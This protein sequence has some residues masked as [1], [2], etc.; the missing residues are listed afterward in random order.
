MSESLQDIKRGPDRSTKEEWLLDYAI[1]SMKKFDKR[2]PADGVCTQAEDAA[3]ITKCTWQIINSDDTLFGVV[4]RQRAGIDASRRVRLVPTPLGVLFLRCLEIDLDYLSMVGPIDQANPFIGLFKR[5]VARNPDADVAAGLHLDQVRYMLPFWTKIRR[6]LSDDELW[7]F[8]YGLNDTVAAIREEGR[9]QPFRSDWRRHTRPAAKN[10]DSLVEM[11]RAL[12]KRH[13]RLLVV[14]VDFGYGK[15][16]QSI[17]YAEVRKHR[18]TLVRYLRRMALS[19]RK[20]FKAYALKLE[21]GL[22]KKWHFHALMFLDGNNVQ[23]GVHHAMTFGEHWKNVITKGKGVYYNCHQNRWKYKTALGI[24]KIEAHEF[25]PRRALETNVAG[26]LVKPDFYGQMMKDA[27]DRLFFKSELPE[28]AERK[29]GRKR[30][31]QDAFADLGSLALPFMPKRRARKTADEKPSTRSN[32]EPA[33]WQDP[34]DLLAQ[35]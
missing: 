6:G 10:Y 13:Q 32:G 16:H 20:V 30:M 27:G 2:T 18:E 34:W 9:T 14:R 15:A 5:H 17:P 28:A 12:F 25:D 26:Y 35:A 29:R 11:I 1:N 8:S 4:R 22:Q 33:Q 24:G 7:A 19:Q 21:H 23:R 3:L 31:K